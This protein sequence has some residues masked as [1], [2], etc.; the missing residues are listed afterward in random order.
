M[1]ESATPVVEGTAS[2]LDAALAGVF[3]AD[4][5]RRTG[6]IRLVVRGAVGLFLV[7]AGWVVSGVP[8]GDAERLAML[9]AFVWAPAAC[10]MDAVV[11]RRRTPLVLSAAGLVELAVFVPA[12]VMLS[13]RGPAVAMLQ[14]PV[15]LLHG[16]MGPRPVAEV[17]A[18]GAFAAAAAAEVVTDQTV[19]GAFGFLALSAGLLMAVAFRYLSL[20]DRESVARLV[21]DQYGKAEALVTGVAEAVVVTTPTGRIREWNDAASRTFSCASRESIGRG[22][23][24]VLGLRRD[25]APLD[26]TTGCAALAARLEGSGDIEFWRVDGAGERQP[27]LVNASPVVGA[28]GRL[29]EVI[30]SF[31]D[32]KGLRL[33]DDAK[34]LFLATASHE[35]KTPLAVIQGYSDLLSQTL[36]SENPVV[37]DGLTAISRR[38]RE[39]SSIVDRLLMTS[40]IEAGKVTVTSLPGDLAAVVTERTDAFRA[41][42]ARSVEVC[43][44]ADLPVV[45]MSTD[46]VATVV[47]HLLDNAAKYS[48]STTPIQVSLAADTEGVSVA[49]RDHGIGMTSDHAE[50]C[51]DK[52]WQAESNDARRYGGT[53]I[54]LYIV[55]ALVEALGGTIIARSTLGEGTTFE[56][57]L[58]RA[59]LPEPATPV[60]DIP[61]E[62]AGEQSIIKEFMRQVGVP[63]SGGNES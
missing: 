21:H 20:G 10:V 13:P 60:E 55:R 39:L 63:S 46:A 16:Y 47:D 49:V 3:S 52:F 5:P 61:D 17:A 48:P 44:T 53:G 26:C 54:G 30:H 1:A 6:G 40:R 14:V 35:L 9:V 12:L 29:R 25:V 59:D 27:L 58:R 32:I 42:T 62:R 34:T 7:S 33:A 24:D 36:D 4:D 43:G 11:R 15:V 50:R 18:V 2:N 28:D 22:C 31:R 38:C 19:V 23:N 51:F 8:G 57:T 37:V 45:S 56:F 41:G